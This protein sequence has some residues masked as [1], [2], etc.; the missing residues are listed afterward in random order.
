MNTPL[1]GVFTGGVKSLPPDGTP[2]GIFKHPVAGPVAVGLEGL[3]G[4][5]QADRRVHGGAEKAVHL[6]PAGHY[7]RLAAAFPALADA[8]V[9]GSMGE[10]LSVAGW[11]EESVCIGDVFRVGSCRLQVSQPR[12]PCWKINHKFGDDG[13]AQFIAHEGI[14]GWYFRVLEGGSVAVGDGF[15]LLE[16]NP[17]PVSLARLGRV[18]R[19]HRPAGAELREIAATPGLTPAL[20]K[21]LLDRLGWLERLKGPAA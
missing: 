16:R 10:N 5:R 14:T 8:L 12:S 15:E 3:E 4:D 9:P 7:A 11:D 21:K 6:Y 20:M 13:L 19:E 2:S 18:Q 17:A 1:L